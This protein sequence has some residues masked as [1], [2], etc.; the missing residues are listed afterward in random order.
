[1]YN[2]KELFFAGVACNISVVKVNVLLNI[3]SGL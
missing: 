3:S 1:M 2:Q